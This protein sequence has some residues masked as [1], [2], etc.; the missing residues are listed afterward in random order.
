MKTPL[1][2][3]YIIVLLCLFSSCYRNVNCPDFDE[4]ILSWFPYEEGNVIRLENKTTDTLLTIPIVY[5]IINHTSHYNTGSD[6]GHCDDEIQITNKAGV[7]ISVYLEKNKIKS[8]HY[9]INSM[10]FYGNAI[11]SE[12]YTFNNKKYEQVKVFEN[13][14]NNSKLIIARN[15][16]IVG[17]IDKDG[18]EWLLVES[19]AMQQL[20]SRITD[21]SCE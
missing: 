19:N 6:C 9:T 18:E 2:I 17:F 20:K 11:I 16:G 4:N 15:F 8:E 13:A 1:N 3:F 21:T 12:N 7:F 5:V 14:G 10:N